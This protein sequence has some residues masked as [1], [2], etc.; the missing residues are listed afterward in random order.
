MAILLRIFNVVLQH[1]A[2]PT[3]YLAWKSTKNVNSGPL[4]P[5]IA[6]KLPLNSFDQIYVF[7]LNRCEV[8]RNDHGFWTLM[9]RIGKHVDQRYAS[10]QS[11][12]HAVKRL[13]HSLRCVNY[14]LRSASCH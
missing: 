1:G 8:T 7:G 3:Q 11:R 10:D 13:P 2:T 5:H 12:K 6:M 14:A 9:H 4:L